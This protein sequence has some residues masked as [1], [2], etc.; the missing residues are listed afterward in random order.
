[1]IYLKYFNDLPFYFA[2]FCITKQFVDVSVLLADGSIYEYTSL[3][4]GL[5]L[6]SFYT[7]EKRRK[8][9]VFRGYRKR[10]VAWN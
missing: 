9:D 5:P 6:V 10:P 2:T 1:M 3:T 7:P 8:L 4:H